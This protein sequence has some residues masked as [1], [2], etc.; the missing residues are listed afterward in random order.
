MNF[1]PLWRALEASRLGQYVASSDWA[2]PT[3]ETVHV[4]ALVAML[5][6][7]LVLDLRLLGVASRSVAV[8][9]VT[10]ATLLFAVPAF[11]LV[12][13][14][15]VL[16]FMSKAPIYMINAYFLAKLVLLGLAGINV[17]IFH[18]LTWRGI[19]V[20]DTLAVSPMPA[21]LAGAFSLAFWIGTVFCSRMIGFTL[22]LY[23]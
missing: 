3:L 4:I 7:I 2:F 16:L 13:L 22:G 12:T 14:S 5:G 1:Q 9:A 8:T 10:R 11:G 17:A 6:A 23:E 19:A 18:L 21:K 20:W 15:G